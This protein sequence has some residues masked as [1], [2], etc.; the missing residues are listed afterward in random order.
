MMTKFRSALLMFFLFALFFAGS[1][2]L[3]ESGVVSPVGENVWEIRSGSREGSRLLYTVTASE[4]E[5][6]LLVET[7]GETEE[8]RY[9]FSGDAKDYRCE[10]RFPD[11]SDWL[12][13]QQN[14]GGTGSGSWYD[15]HML[16]S[17]YPD[18][19]DLCEIIIESRAKPVSFDGTKILA[20]L[21]LAGVGL[22]QLLAPETAWY[23]SYGWR[24]KDAEPSDAALIMG[25][26]G[27][28]V[29]LGAA[30]FILI[31]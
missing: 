13:S 10:I 17:P 5:D 22:F 4:E 7:D 14:G 8:Y 27:G 12:W 3:A 20:V 9:E 2:V 25:R 28:V 30:I 6:V 21:L 1:V 29:A 23:L 11:G 16:E 19:D 31:I 24:Y 18:P 15:T 26:V